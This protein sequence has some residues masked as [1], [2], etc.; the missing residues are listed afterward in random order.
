MGGKIWVESKENIGSEFIFEIALK[1]L[2]DIEK[3]TKYK[4]PKQSAKNIL[5]SLATSH[6]LLAEDN[7]TNQE[8][9]VGLLEESGIHIDIANNGKEA[10]E[11]YKKDK[12]KY[13]LILMDI[14][15]PIMDGYEATKIIREQNREIPIIAITANAMREDVERTQAVGMNAHLNKPIEVEK[16]YETVLKYV[17]KKSD[18]YQKAHRSS[19]NDII[20]PKFIH[21]DTKI[22]LQYT[23]ENKKLYLKI[24]HN[25]YSDFHN[26]NLNQINSDVY[27]RTLHT[28][29]GLS[30]NIGAIK[31][32]K[33]VKALEETEDR[34]LIIPLEIELKKVLDELTVLTKEHQPSDDSRA[35]IDN[36]LKIELFNQLKEFCSKRR[37]NKIKIVIKEIEKY[38][39]ND[40]DKAWFHEIKN[41]INKYDF[42]EAIEIMNKGEIK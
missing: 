34:S 41:A 5:N 4:T 11:L 18:N 9:I 1:E 42:K 14:Q 28:L 33:S 29:K 3:E 39:L 35:L 31:L 38:K 10:V 2:K 30:S 12:D 40:E 23:A 26:I 37:T 27:K 22:G 36:T 25:F 15:M 21:I 13:E 16:L 8:I 7:L 32:N 17:S 19:E 24:L 6:I 20:I